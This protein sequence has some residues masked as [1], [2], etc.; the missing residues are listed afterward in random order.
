MDGVDITMPG[1]P[2]AYGE[3]RAAGN[4]TPPERPGMHGREV[5]QDWL[6]M[7]GAEVSQIEEAGGV[8]PSAGSTAAVAGG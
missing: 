1:K 2:W 6:G 4:T 8:S 7:S 3:S 5:L